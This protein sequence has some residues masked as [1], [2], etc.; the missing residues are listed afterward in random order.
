MQV[1]DTLKELYKADLLEKSL[2][3]EFYRPGEDDPFLSLGGEQQILGGSMKITEALSSSENLDF[4]SCEA[5]QLEITVIDVEKDIIGSTMRVYQ[6]LQG[7]L[8]PA[9]D[10]YPSEDLYPAGFIMPFGT[11]IVQTA[12]RQTNGRYRDV[13]ALDRMILFDVNVIN[14]YD[15]LTFPM[16]LKDFR[17]SLCK[18]IGVDQEVP[19]DIPNDDM[20]VEKTI[21][22][23]EL[24]GRD[25]LIACE[26]INGVFGHFDRNG[27]LQHVKVSANV[28]TEEACAETL[29]TY[30][31]ISCHSEEYTVQA[32][33]K[34]RIRQEEG[35]IG[36]IYGEGKN[37]YTIEGNFLVFGKSAEELARI[38]TNAYGMISGIHYIPYE[39]TG[40]GLPYVSIGDMV[41]L[42]KE[43]IATY[44]MKRTL[45][46]TS[47]LKDEYGAT[48]EEIRSTENNVNTEIIQLKGRSAVLK[49]T[50]EEISA[51][52]TDLDAKTQAQFKVLSDEI[53]MK[54]SKGDVSSQLSVETDRVYIAGNR[55]VV[56]ST[57][58][59]L[60]EKGNVTVTGNVTGSTITGS[61]FDSGTFY[62][63]ANEVRFGDFYVS[64]ND[65]Y[66]LAA[67]DGSVM[68]R[69]AQNPDGSLVASMTLGTG[70]NRTYIHGGSGYFGGGV[71]AYSF[72]G[73]GITTSSMYDLKLGKSWWMDVSITE[74]VQFLSD[75]LWKLATIVDDQW[76]DYSGVYDALDD[77]YEE[78]KPW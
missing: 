30:L 43:G 57:N 40:K 75:C 44:V 34:V 58:F 2:F 32:I 20:L 65:K 47:A 36:A 12:P 51:T 42:Q 38:A 72:K 15:S 4:G 28:D 16:T 59:K 23:T 77:Y 73:T 45:T 1:D 53:T 76:S 55:L 5:T 10:L 67:K 74:R 33:E 21:D 18:H 26:Q 13:L 60:D 35:D 37:C 22:T 14:W 50:V 27:V 63:D 52:V 62:A 19:D 61:T 29:E 49:R 7:S 46:G 54:V 56:D 78:N 17:A 71:D 8:F 11:Y 64:V 39:Y 69:T 6:V 3:L 25:V 24:V 31:T 9:E 68:F 70:E 41:W 66:T 48:G